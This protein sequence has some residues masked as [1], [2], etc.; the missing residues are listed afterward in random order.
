MKRKNVRFFL[1]VAISWFASSTALAQAQS[2]SN[3]NLGL[4]EAVNSLYPPEA[5]GFADLKL[6][7]LIYQGLVGYDEHLKLTPSLAKS[8]EIQ[9]GGK[10]SGFSLA[11]RCLFFTI[12]FAFRTVR[13]R[14]VKAS[15]FKY[16]FERICTPAPDNGKQLAVN[17]FCGWSTSIFRSKSS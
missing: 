2:S 11:L 12:T 6:M 9:E 10:T 1:V 7:H 15:D 13:V 14:A 16:C 5:Y 3:L 17:R 4:N 8:W